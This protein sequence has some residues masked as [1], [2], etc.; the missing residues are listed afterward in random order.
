MWET[1]PCVR[2][3]SWGNATHTGP[4]TID[5]ELWHTKATGVRHSNLVNQWVFID[6]P[7]RNKGGGVIYRIRMTQK[8]LLLPK[9]LPQFE[10][11]PWRLHPRNSA[12]LGVS[13]FPDLWHLLTSGISGASFILEWIFQT[14]ENCYTTMLC[15]IFNYGIRI[16]LHYV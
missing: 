8:Q 15:L 13:P 10:G 12:S 4:L 2:D 5:R 6:V 7:N 11:D 9:Y 14:R 1:S 16:K 3:F